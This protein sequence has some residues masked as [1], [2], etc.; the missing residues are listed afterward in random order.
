VNWPAA[1]LSALLMALGAFLLP[2]GD[3]SQAFAATVRDARRHRSPNAGWPE[4]ALAGALGFALNGPRSYHG[5]PTDEPWTN[6]A[7]RKVLDAPDIW[8][9]LRLYLRACLLLA[10]G[11]VAVAIIAH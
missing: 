2:G 5:S 6:E 7:G 10:A 8:Q 1:R 3:G 4:A 9:A 11:V